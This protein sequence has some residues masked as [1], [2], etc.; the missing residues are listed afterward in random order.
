MFSFQNVENIT[1]HTSYMGILE[2]VSYTLVG[3]KPQEHMQLYILDSIAAS[4]VVVASLLF[5]TWP[6]LEICMFHIGEHTDV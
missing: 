6:I 5:E 3:L 1:I 2:K 4:V